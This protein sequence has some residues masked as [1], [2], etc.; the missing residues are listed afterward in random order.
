VS[1]QLRKL[2]D[3]YELTNKIGADRIFDTAKDLSAAFK[4]A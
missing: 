4:T 1:P 3:A 2:L